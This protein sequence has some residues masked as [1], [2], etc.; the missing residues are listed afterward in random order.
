MPAAGSG[1]GSPCPGTGGSAAARPS[2]PAR[3][4]GRSRGWRRA[5]RGRREGWRRP[6]RRCGR[7]KTR[8]SSR[9][10]DAITRSPARAVIVL[11]RC[12]AVRG[13]SRDRTPIGSAAIHG[14]ADDEEPA[15]SWTSRPTSAMPGR[16]ELDGIDFDAFRADPLDD[17]S[18]RCLRY[19]HDV[20]HHTVCYLRDLL[21]TPAHR[22]PDMTTFL[23]MWTFEE[24][25]HGEAIATVLRAHGE[26]AGAGRIAPLRRRLGWRDRVA[27]LVHG[28]GSAVVGAPVHRRPH[29][30]GR[31]ERVDDPGRL[32][33]AGR[34]GPAPGADRAAAPDHAPGG[35]A[36]R[37][38]RP[39]GHRPPRR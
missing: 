24:F 4:P 21:V 30:L 23:T 15:C 16:V 31:G 35:P 33:P 7:K 6:R 18:L 28:V 8:S 17:D 26:P 37:L 1:R 29:D 5:G 39:P 9:A 32:R 22:D 38:L 12:R 19:M 14:R 10:S 25:W 34:P 3:R 13:S 20:E 2:A 36:H 27:P 11:L